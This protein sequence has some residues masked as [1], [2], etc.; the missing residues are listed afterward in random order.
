MGTSSREEQRH[1]TRERVY[2]AAIAEYKRVGMA[3]ADVGVI[4]KEAGVA[5]GTFYFHFPTKEHV[6]AELE[7]HE[8]ART[9]EQLTRFLAKPHNLEAALREVVRLMSLIERHAGKVL[10]RELLAL[11]FSPRRPE[12]LPGTDRWGDYPMMT[13]VVRAVELARERG[14]TYPG[15]DALSTAQFFMLGLYAVLITSHEHSRAARAEILGN[16]VATVL[17]S[18]EP[19]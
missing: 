11:H 5:R 2:A 9:A 12:V 16:F 17:R 4:V 1:Q 7:R 3:A 13:L 10:F 14:E 8:E 6:L 15:A 19:R 18:V